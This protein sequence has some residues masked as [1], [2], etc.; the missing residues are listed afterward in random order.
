MECEHCKIS[1]KTKYSLKSHLVNN[2]ACLKLR[3]LTLDTQFICKG[4]DAIF[5]NNT[6][7]S[8]HTDTCRKYIVVLLQEE[9]KQELDRLEEEHKKH[10]DYLKKEHYSE[11]DSVTKDY[12]YEVEQLKKEH[13]DTIKEQIEKITQVHRDET[14]EMSFETQLKYN[15]LQTRYDEL[16]KQHDKTISKLEIK[17]SQCDSFI[18]MLAR[19]GSNKPT[20]TTTNTVNNNIRNVLSS[21]YTLDKLESTHIEETLREHY[22][23]R[24]FC[25]GQKALAE[26]CVKKLIKTTDGKMMLCCSDMSRKKFKILDMNGNIKDDTEAREFCRKLKIP[27]QNVTKEIYDRIEAEIVEQKSRLS[28]DDYSHRQKLID[29]SLRAQNLYI[30]IMNFD[31]SNYNQEFIHELCVLLS[32]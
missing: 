17:I 5:M 4:C 18:Q 15:E 21:E 22:T 2:K 25:N 24:D 3:G 16:S 27:I 12:N 6:N 31:D 9:H 32:Y 28:T 13:S 14:K 7:L 1:V 23:E 20:T 26:F 11:L 29:D 30:D 8:V 19:E 10:I